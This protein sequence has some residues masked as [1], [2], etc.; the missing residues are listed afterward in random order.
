[1]VHVKLRLGALLSLL[2]LLSLCT[3]V[4]YVNNI[5][6][7][8]YHVQ[9]RASLAQTSTG[10]S[11][12]KPKIEYFSNYTWNTLDLFASVTPTLLN[13]TLMQFTATNFYT[14]TTPY[15]L[16]NFIVKIYNGSTESFSLYIFN[17]A[18]PTQYEPGQILNQNTAITAT[19]TG[20][21]VFPDP[22]LA[23]F[24]QIGFIYQNIN[25]A[26][27]T[28]VVYYQNN[29]SVKMNTNFYTPPEVILWLFYGV[30]VLIIAQ[31]AVGVLGKRYVAKNSNKIRKFN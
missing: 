7:V 16:Q 1:M 9:P 2:V 3:Q 14:N 26:T 8:S 28:G 12:L 6:A 11:V 10:F 13:D 18:Y 19:Q 5:Q 25:N 23:Y 21:L 15:A 20:R 4:T 17:D 29:I 31:V 22:T 24:L 27:D 30:T